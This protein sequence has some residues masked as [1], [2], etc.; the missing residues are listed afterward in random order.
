MENV[1]QALNDRNTDDPAKIKPDF[2]VDR[3]V[4]SI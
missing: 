2:F 1:Y 4:S 3:A